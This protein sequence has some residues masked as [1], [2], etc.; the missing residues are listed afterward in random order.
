MIIQL[1]AIIII[2]CIYLSNLVHTPTLHDGTA[3]LHK[4]STSQ[5][6]T[7]D[8]LNFDAQIFRQKTKLIDQNKKVVIT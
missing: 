2:L 8:Q 3:L 4:T 5:T 7:P 6:P 1:N